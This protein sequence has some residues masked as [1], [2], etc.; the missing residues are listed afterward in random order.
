MNPA[1]L[2]QRIA[3]TVLRQQE[4]TAR[5]VHPLHEVYIKAL[6]VIEARW[7][8]DDD[9]GNKLDEL[10]VLLRR[11]HRQL[12]AAA[13]DAHVTGGI[14]PDEDQQQEQDGAEE[15]EPSSRNGG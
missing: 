5:R 4:R 2:Q 1:E 13:V 12:A 8:G 10:A 3:L 6:E 14:L 9:L 7:E 15:L 11:T